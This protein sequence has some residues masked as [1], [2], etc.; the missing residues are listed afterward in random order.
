MPLP[1]SG[2]S[3]RV[4]RDQAVVRGT[5]KVQP[6]HS[7]SKDSPRSHLAPASNLHFK[8]HY[9]VSYFSMVLVAKEMVFCLLQTREPKGISGYWF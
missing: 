3:E 8:C 7:Q 1:G 9:R 6:S 4:D 2:G 5:S